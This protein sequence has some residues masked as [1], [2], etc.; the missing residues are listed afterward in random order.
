[1]MPTSLGM[2]CLTG[3][4]V[5]RSKLIGGL[6]IYRIIIPELG[7]ILTLP[8]VLLLKLIRINPLLYPVHVLAGDEVDLLPRIGVDER[9]NRTPSE[10]EP[11]R[12]VEY[13]HLVEAA[14]EVHG[15]AV[16]DDAQAL[17]RKAE[18]AHLIG[19]QHEYP[20]L[21]TAANH[22]VFAHDSHEEAQGLDDCVPR[23]LF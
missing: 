5:S 4:P 11:T 10:V 17:E 7:K 14:T 1:M 2:D 22:H 6:K 23:I 21:H 12:G 16:D 8:S 13:V 15:H 20:I 18:H 3:Y 9:F 19:L